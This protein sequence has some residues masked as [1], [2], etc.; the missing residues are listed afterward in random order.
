[1]ACYKIIH[2]IRL[3]ALLSFLLFS[4][5]SPAMAGEGY[6][7]NVGEKL[8]R[9]L[10][11]VVTGW[12]EIPKN[13][14]NTSRDSNVGIGVTLGLVKGI[15]QTIGRTLVGA[16]EL[17]TFFIPTPGLVHPTYIFEDFYRDTTYGTAQA[18]AS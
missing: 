17:A 6:G 12:L 4:F 11:N 1:M 7:A 15:G 10:V 13:V 8:G 16:G 3:I 5:A 2:A 14:V 18:A 9:G